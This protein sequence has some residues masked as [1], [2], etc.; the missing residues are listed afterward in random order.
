M[1]RERQPEINRSVWSRRG[2]VESFPSEPT[3][4]D[5]GEQ[6]A[7]SWVLDAN[8]VPSVLDLG[9]GA[10]RTAGLLA[11]RASTYVGLDYSA[12]MV[13]RARA[14]YPRA[15]IRIGDARDLHAFADGSVDLVTFSF[16]GIDA[17]SHA[18][19]R[20]VLGEMHRVIRAGGYVLYSTLNTLGGLY[21]ERPWR[22]YELGAAPVPTRSVRHLVRVLRT[23]VRHPRSCV[24]WLKLHRFEQAHPDWGIGVLS[25]HDFSILAHFTTPSAAV[26]EARAAGFEVERVYAKSGALL[27]PADPQT[28]E[29]WIHVVARRTADG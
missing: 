22:R 24:N 15:D 18:D 25:A 7:L 5:D 11:E 23:A 8:P 21:G 27:D 20:R 28:D 17:V 26:A 12:A 3:W 9:V 2:Y 19:R 14:A 4:T 1:N 6:A 13:E 16:N 10:G 29:E